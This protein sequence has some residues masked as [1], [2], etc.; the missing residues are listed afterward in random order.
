MSEKFPVGLEATHCVHTPCAQ[1]GVSHWGALSAD[2]EDG[3]F[4][5]AG[6]EEE[7]EGEGGASAEFDALIAPFKLLA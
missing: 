3:A 5:P 2:S 7:K 6:Q 4:E 1:I